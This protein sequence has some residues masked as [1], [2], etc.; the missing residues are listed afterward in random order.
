MNLTFILQLTRQDFVDRYSGSILGA[1]WAVIHPLAMIFIFVVI[2]ANVM[3]TRLPSIS[4]TYSYSIYLVSGLLPW[5]AFANTIN[6]TASVFLDKRNIIT[7]IYV[8][9]PYLPLYVLLSESITFFIAFTIFFFFLAITGSL[10]GMSLLVLPIVFLLQ[11]IL[12]FGL[13]LMF[14]ILNVFLRDI[15]EFLTV[16][17]TFWFWLTPIVWVLDIVPSLVQ[18]GQIFLNPAFLFIDAYQ[19]ILVHHEWPDGLAL[20]RLFII[21]SLSVL[22]AYYLLRWLEKDV[23]DFL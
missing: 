5:L 8:S 4:S 2:F 11:Q 19:R 17:M 9:L 6:R 10:P 16:L 22:M 18:K 13:G 1:L 14:G 21:A 12:A 15:K 3:G 23:R 7:K 20:L